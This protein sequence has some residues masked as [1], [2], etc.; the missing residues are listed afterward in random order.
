MV[1]TAPH[2]LVTS[3]Y[4]K[5]LWRSMIDLLPLRLAKIEQMAACASWHW[6]LSF[7]A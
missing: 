3:V 5:S 7:A 2:G 1:N 6:N 4:A